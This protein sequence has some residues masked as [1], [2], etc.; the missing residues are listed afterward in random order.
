MESLY[1]LAESRPI[2]LASIN[3][4]SEG[5]ASVAV[6]GAREIL[7][8]EP[9]ISHQLAD[10]TGED[11][12]TFENTLSV[13]AAAGVPSTE[14]APTLRTLY[15]PTVADINNISGFQA[16]FLWEAG[17]KTSVDIVQ[18]TT[19]ELTEVHEIGDKTAQE[20]QTAAEDLLDE[21]T[22]E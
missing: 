22:T 15:G 2:E 1:H 20:I 18:A 6:E 12:E 4:I 3:G 8:E 10:E 9:P 14:A 21:V 7:G 11:K 13:L 16:Y 17:Y 5:I 19:D